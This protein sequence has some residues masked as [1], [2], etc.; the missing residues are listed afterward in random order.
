MPVQGP[1][2]NARVQ[3]A[4]APPMRMKPKPMPNGGEK[5]TQAQIGRPSIPSFTRSRIADPV[6]YPPN[7]TE[8]QKAAI[9]AENEREKAAI[10]DAY[11]SYPRPNNP[12]WKLRNYIGQDIWWYRKGITATT[13]ECGKITAILGDV[14]ECAVWG[15]NRIEH[16]RDVYHVSHPNAADPRKVGREG[17]G[18]WDFMPTPER[19]ASLKLES[20]VAELKAVVD[21]LIRQIPQPALPPSNQELSS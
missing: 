13:P 15:P 4:I 16:K 12:N 9:D 18:V 21:E 14:I 11:F 3:G 6:R 20:E 7:A 10:A 2:G 8:E 17:V 5:P 1:Q 19:E